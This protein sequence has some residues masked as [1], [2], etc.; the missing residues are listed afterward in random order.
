MENKQ[1]SLTTPTIG[2]S[3]FARNRHLVRGTGKSFFCGP[4]DSKLSKD[5]ALVAIIKLMWDLRSPGHGR[6][7]DEVVT[8]PIPTDQCEGNTALI[9]DGCRL[10]AKLDRRQEGEESFISVRVEET[11]DIRN[12][13][14]SIPAR[15]DPCTYASVV[16]YNRQLV[17]EEDLMGCGDCEW[18]VV[19]LLASA[20]K[21][22]P[23]HPITMAR[24]FLVKKG[25]T[26]A[27]YTAADF[28]KSI[29]YWKDRCSVAT[30]E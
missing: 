22:E 20:V 8:V 29:W 15:P 23:M 28:A 1:M 24:N 7:L 4:K 19:A 6:F 26:K 21:D 12:P 27:C 16:L 10:S 9:H 5:E 11:A 3:N 18:I 25:G 14:R 17:P 2:I 30:T 13:H